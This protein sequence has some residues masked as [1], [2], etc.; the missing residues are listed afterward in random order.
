MVD[1]DTQFVELSQ[2]TGP[3]SIIRFFSVPQKHWKKD[4][5]FSCTVNQGFSGS[6]IS[7]STGNIFVDPSVELLLVPGEESAQQRLSCSGWGFDPQIKW[8]SGSQQKSPST[9]DI[10]MGADGRVA[11]TSQLL[12]PQTEWKTGISFTCEVSDRSLNKNVRKD[13]NVCSACST[14]PPSIHLET[15]SFKTVMMAGSEVTATCLVRTAFDATVT[16]LM[17]GTVT[18]RR[19]VKTK[20]ETHVIS[21]VTLPLSEWKEL[22]SI[23]CK[24]EHKCFKSIER[25][26]DVAVPSSTAP[27]IQIRRSLPHLL[28]G[29]SAVLECDIT[30][31]DSRDL[32]VTLKANMVDI[33]TQFVELSQTT[34]PHSIIRFFSV[35]Q[36]HWKKDTSFS[37]T[38]NQGFSG[39][40]ISNSTG[41]IFVDPSVELLLVPGEES[42]QQRL[43]CSGWGFDPQIK[44]S[45]G[46]QQK[47]P[48]TYDISMGADG[49]VAVTSRLLVPQTEWKT[50]KSFNCDVSD[51]TLK[52]NVQQ[53]I[54]LCSVI[55][56][57]SQ[58]V[59]VYIQGP[60]LQEN[61]NMGQVTVTCLL[62]G[63]LLKD[64]S[65]FWKVDGNTYTD[66]A[67]IEP[68][69]RHSNGT[70]TMRSFLNVSAEDWNSYKK[71]SCEGKHPCFKQSYGDHINKCKDTS[72]P[73]VKI[74]KPSAS[75]SSMSH[76]LKLTCLVSEFFPSN[77]IVYWKKDGQRLPSTGYTNSPAWKYTGSSTYSMSSRLN[78][79]KTMNEES[80]YSCVVR[81][82]SSEMPLESSIKDVFDVQGS[83]DYFEDIVNAEGIQ[84]K[85]EESWLMAFTF[86]V[87][88]LISIV[89][90]VVATLL[91]VSNSSFSSSGLCLK[92]HTLSLLPP[93]YIVIYM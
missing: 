42:A 7:N 45:S 41:N 79:T 21:K 8:S 54:S 10:S 92:S 53:E 36:K 19:S 4:T 12:V 85:D 89:Y 48:S 65:I 25:T 90:G 16:W 87:F 17:N 57:S 20:N 84:D 73:T 26:V 62:V 80:I 30:Q 60:P 74:I 55:P 56:A 82:E 64:I 86:L 68:P 61:Q 31:L 43:S 67:H 1:I 29:N 71:V 13:I 33:D 23:T 3:H 75:Q 47:S 52:K 44:W 9:Y 2:T 51:R 32:S 70:E 69:V 22:L 50:G 66:R 91:K 14:I 28:K 39:S 40:S 76:F 18:T 27:L 58:S 35:P 6:S 93:P 63:P 46:S 72:P 15:P 83:C 81:H 49:R 38:V 88:F 77:I 37:C 59:G 11:V 78:I 34:G 24:A 5:S